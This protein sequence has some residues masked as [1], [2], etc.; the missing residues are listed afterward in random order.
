[1]A[2]VEPRRGGTPL[3]TVRKP[4][5]LGSTGMTKAPEGATLRQCKSV[6]PIQGLENGSVRPP[7]EC[8]ASIARPAAGRMSRPPNCR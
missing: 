5:E 3:A 6:A 1:M 8:H 4:V 2:S 7:A